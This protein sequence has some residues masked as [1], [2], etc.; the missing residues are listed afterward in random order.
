MLPP[1]PL[2]ARKGRGAVSNLQGRYEVDTREPVDDGWSYEGADDADEAADIA[3]GNEG[4]EGKESN[5]A[6]TPPPRLKTHITNEHAKTIL[7]RNATP[8]NP[9]NV[10]HKPNRGC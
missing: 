8:D 5:D 6:D 10:S 4:R 2:S 3:D 1:R 9:F 7:S